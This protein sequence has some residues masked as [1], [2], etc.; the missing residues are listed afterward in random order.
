MGR[1]LRKLL[2]TS[3]AS[4]NVNSR[5]IIEAVEISGYNTSRIA[6]SL[7]TQLQGLVGTSYDTE[8]LENLARELRKE[9]HAKTVT[10]HIA[11][12]SS[13]ERVKVVFEVTRRTAALD[14]S[15]PKFLY[16][17]KQGWSAQ[18]EATTTVTRNNNLMFGV[19]SDG[20]ELTERYAGIHAGYENLHVGTDK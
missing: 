10:Q 13:A 12:G 20:D 2:P 17:S 11:R 4:V 1:K 18:V 7:R 3:S 15:V 6:G 5:Y 14:I 19:V 8:I 16:H 9:I